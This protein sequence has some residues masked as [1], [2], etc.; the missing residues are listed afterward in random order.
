LARVGKL[1]FIITRLGRSARTSL[2][3]PHLARAQLS[4]VWEDT[5]LQKFEWLLFLS[6]FYNLE[7]Q[8]SALFRR[9]SDSYSCNAANVLK[10]S[11]KK[12]V[13]AWLTALDD[14]TFVTVDWTYRTQLLLDAGVTALISPSVAPLADVQMSIMDADVLIDDTAGIQSFS[15]FLTVYGLQGNNTANSRFKFL[16]NKKVFKTDRRR[17]AFGIDD[18]AQSSWGMPDM[19]QHGE[20]AKRAPIVAQSAN[21]EIDSLVDLIHILWPSYLGSWTPQYMRNIALNENFDTVT[22]AQCPRNDTSSPSVVPSLSCSPITVTAPS[23]SEPAPVPIGAIVGGVIA[24]VAVIAAVGLGA[25]FYKRKKNAPADEEDTNGFVRMD[26]GSAPVLP[27]GAAKVL[28][29]RGGV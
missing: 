17:N 3:L 1:T 27:E 28:E 26:E 21:N 20:R 22:A 19:V 10:L 14:G 24:G 15:D 2:P 6:T 25:F 11:E 29:R 7:D 5:P 8:A 4:A 9:V 18:F 16:A 12:P 23:T 13:V